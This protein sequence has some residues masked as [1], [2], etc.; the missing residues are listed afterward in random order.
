MRGDLL[1]A[2]RILSLETSSGRLWHREKAWES[3]VQ[4]KVA[5]AC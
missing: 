4:E 1:L 2:A 3:G 5:I